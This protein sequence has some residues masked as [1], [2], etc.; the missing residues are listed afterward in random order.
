MLKNIPPLTTQG[1]R[2]LGL[3][4]KDLVQRAKPKI[5]AD[6][7]KFTRYS[8]KYRGLKHPKIIDIFQ[9]H[10]PLIRLIP[11]ED[12]K[13]VA[14]NLITQDFGED[15]FLGFLIF[16]HIFSAFTIDD[17]IKY[18]EALFDEG[19]IKSVSAADDYCERFVHKWLD[20]S[21]EHKK[22]IVRWKDGTHV[23]RRRV[24]CI[25][26]LNHARYGD[27]SP[28]NFAGFYDMCLGICETMIK[29]SEKYHQNAVGLLLREL[30]VANKSGTHAF[31][32]K[33]MESLTI[34]CMRAATDKLSV[35]EKKKLVGMC[36]ERDIRKNQ[37]RIMQMQQNLLKQR[38][39][40]AAKAAEMK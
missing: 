20:L 15:K 27:R 35:E 37:Q 29:S 40:M 2:L 25:G 4:Q 14:Y 19:Y 18:H 34:E 7:E 6:I 28:P 5:K 32:E 38:E 30:F 13:P 16:E 36:L 39:E 8:Q 10:K 11:Y 33:N 1:T 3:L 31:I 26:L 23:W 9:E 12:L 22:Y 17:V 24:S 21:Q